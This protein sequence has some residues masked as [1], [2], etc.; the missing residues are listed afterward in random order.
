MVIRT[1]AAPVDISRSCILNICSGRLTEIFSIFSRGYGPRLSKKN[2]EKFYAPMNHG[3]NWDITV[4]NLMCL[5][6]RRARKAPFKRNHV[7]KTFTLIYYIHQ[8]VPLIIYNSQYSNPQ[9]V[10]KIFNHCN[11]QNQELKNRDTEGIST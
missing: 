10:L 2:V 7:H 5:I 3:P 1:C 9:Q 11:F 4:C 6:A 8:N